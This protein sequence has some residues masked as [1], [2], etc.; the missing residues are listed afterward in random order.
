MSVAQEN[1]W[2]PGVLPSF[3]LGMSKAPRVLGVSDGRWASDASWLDVFR[4]GDEARGTVVAPC[5]HTP[6]AC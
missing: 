3:V 6:G 4:D 5:E 1:A 2:Y